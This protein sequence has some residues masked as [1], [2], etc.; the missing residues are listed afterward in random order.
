MP[1]RWYVVQSKNNSEILAAQNLRHQKFRCCLPLLRQTRRVRS[2]DV[3]V[4]S[5]LFPSYLF[6]QFDV[7]R[8]KWRGINGTRGVSRLLSATEDS[9]TPLPKGFVELLSS[10]I[11]RK[12]FIMIE[13]AEEVVRKFVIGDRIRV[14]D[15]VFQGFTGTCTRVKKDSLVV[16]LHLLSGKVGVEFPT[17]TVEVV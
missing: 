4:V 14:K 7:Q 3:V 13:Q 10:K 1:R 17:G 6:V 8:A 5:A 11:D 15:G 2:K 12:G 16:L 9:V